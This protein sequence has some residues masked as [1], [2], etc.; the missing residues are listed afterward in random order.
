LG[1]KWGVRAMPTERNRERIGYS[2][3][4]KGG[5]G[6]SGENLISQTQK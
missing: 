3:N 6:P 4:R 5:G 2:D 1:V